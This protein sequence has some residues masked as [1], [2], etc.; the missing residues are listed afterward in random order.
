M[1][2]LKHIICLGFLLC[3]V[4]SCSKSTRTKTTIKTS[5]TYA[6]IGTDFGQFVCDIN[7]T[8]GKLNGCQDSGLLALGTA[9]G[10]HFQYS[11]LA[12]LLVSSQTYAYVPNYNNGIVYQCVIDPET[13]VLN[14]CVDTGV[15]GLNG[16]LAIAINQASNGNTFV[17]IRESND[18]V[19]ACPLDTVTGQLST[20][21]PPLVA[22]SAESSMA[23]YTIGGNTYLYLPS[24]STTM[25]RC[26]MTASGSVT[27]CQAQTIT[28]LASSDS[29]AVA[30]I[31]NQ[32]YAYIADPGNTHILQC[33][34]SVV[35]GSLT[36]CV[37]V[38]Q[39]YS[40]YS[41]ASFSINNQS[42]LYLNSSD[43]YYSALACQL[44]S[45]SGIVQDCGESGAGSLFY[46]MYFSF[47]TVTS[48]T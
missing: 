47:A 28:G 9:I 24:G 36:N 4:A 30:T 17:Y 31:N 11:V 14:S 45:S 22:V 44:N 38:I 26:T 39:P 8:T 18:D 33:T 35:D 34:I 10:A 15:G 7:P 16:P 6:Y 3:T 12:T 48:T 40:V 43:Y 1:M 46:Y 21:L 29:I 37:P 41:L 23:F 5:N 27:N 13:G 42:F 32:G 25:E 19:V 2:Y 20:C